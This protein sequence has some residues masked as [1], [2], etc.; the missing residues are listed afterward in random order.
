MSSIDIQALTASAP[1]PHTK[2]R[3]RAAAQPAS[4]KI[5]GYIGRA[6]LIGAA[7]AFAAAIVPVAAI[8]SFIWLAQI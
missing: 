1:L 3:R 5:A 7:L 2:S 4:P 6:V 8:Y